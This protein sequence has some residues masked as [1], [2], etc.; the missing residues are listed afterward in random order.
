MF[1]VGSAMTDWAQFR[2]WEQPV[3][4]VG[5]MAIWWMLRAI[6]HTYRIPQAYSSLNW[7]WSVTYMCHQ[8]SIRDTVSGNCVQMVGDQKSWWLSTMYE[9][10]LNMWPLGIRKSWNLTGMGCFR[11]FEGV[12]TWLSGSHWDYTSLFQDFDPFPDA[13]LQCCICILRLVK[14]T[15]HR[16]VLHHHSTFYD[17]D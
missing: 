1:A 5:S 3:S 12:L 11:H 16:L 2:E 6:V 15:G 4:Y 8:V 14:H 17:F 13:W 9:I 10:T 7:D